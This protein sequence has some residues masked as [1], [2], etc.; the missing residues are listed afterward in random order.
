MKITLYV[1]LRQDI[2]GTQALCEPYPDIDTLSSTH[3]GCRFK[4]DRD[5]LT[6]PSIAQ[7]SPVVKIVQL[8]CT[9]V[10]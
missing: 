1:A 8:D 5:D 2:E 7:H 9:E 6:F 3:E 4:A 10:S